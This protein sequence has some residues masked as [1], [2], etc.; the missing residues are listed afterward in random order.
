[1]ERAGRASFNGALAEKTFAGTVLAFSRAHAMVGWLRLVGRV[2]IDHR[3][4]DGFLLTS[5]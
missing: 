4:G 3:P 1:M 2:P 5:Q